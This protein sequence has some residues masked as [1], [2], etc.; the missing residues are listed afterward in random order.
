M[1]K[2]NIVK[3]RLRY[4]VIGS[5]GVKK[6]RKAGKVPTYR[7]QCISS[8]YTLKLAQKAEAKYRASN[9]KLSCKEEPKTVRHLLKETKLAFLLAV[10]AAVIIEA[11]IK[12]IIH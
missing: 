10:L 3:H 12:F 2:F 5:E 7:E 8:H 1:T 4:H 11:Y 9:L 6:P